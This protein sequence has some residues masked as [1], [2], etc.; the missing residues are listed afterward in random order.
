MATRVLN[1]LTAKAV[2]TFQGPGLL[3]DGGNLYVHADGNGR[4]R[5]VFIYRSPTGKKQRHMGLGSSLAGGVTLAQ[6]REQAAAARTLL[7]QGKDPIEVRT[8]EDVARSAPN[9][10]VPSFGEVADAYVA[11]HEGGWQNKKHAAQWK[12]TLTVHAAPMRARP[13]N[14]VSTQDVVDVLQPIWT[15]IPE[16]AQRLRGRIEAVLDAAKVQGLRSGENPARWRGHLQHLLS[17]PQKLKRGHMRA[18]PYTEIPSFVEKLRTRKVMSA[19]LLEFA[20]LTAV[21]PG[22][23]R[24]AKWSEFDLEQRVWTVPGERMKAGDRHRV[25]LSDRALEILAEMQAIASGD[26]VFPSPTGKAYSDG[27]VTNLL[28][29]MG[30]HAKAVPHGFRSTFRDWLG[31]CT[32]FDHETGEA[33]LAHK[34]DNKAAAAYRRSD[35]LEKRR[36]AMAAWARYC[37][38]ETEV[39]TLLKA[40]S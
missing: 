35:Q 12:M 14:E 9:K 31:D 20:I 10:A 28:K 30:F 38:G 37:A 32:T 40:A 11:T 18:L 29:R 5:W 19:S 7:R 6:A 13:I 15:T 39:V 8:N 3:G 17:A 33:A 1:K 34:I 22:E 16:T 26:V 25:P 2:A 24:G 4:K 21:R 36:D 23:A 27:A